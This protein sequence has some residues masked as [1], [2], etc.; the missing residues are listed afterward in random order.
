[1]CGKDEEGDG[2]EEG[3]IPQRRGR[4]DGAARVFDKAAS[5]IPTTRMLEEDM[6][7]S[8][9]RHVVY[10]HKLAFALQFVRYNETTKHFSWEYTFEEI[11]DVMRQLKCPLFPYKK[12]TTKRERDEEDKPFAILRDQFDVLQMS[13]WYLDLNQD[14]SY[15]SNSPNSRHVQE[16]G[17]T[18]FDTRDDPLMRGK[19]RST[20]KPAKERYLGYRA[21]NIEEFLLTK[22]KVNDA[23][24]LLSKA[25]K[26]GDLGIFVQTITECIT[27]EVTSSSANT[28]AERTANTY[29][30][31]SVH[32]QMMAVPVPSDDLLRDYTRAKSRTTPEHLVMYGKYL[33]GTYLFPFSGGAHVKVIPPGAAQRELGRAAIPMYDEIDYLL[34][35]AF[36]FPVSKTRESCEYLSKALA[37][38][39]KFVTVPSVKRTTD[40]PD[41]GS[42]LLQYFQN[43]QQ[44]AVGG[45]SRLLGPKTEGESGVT[46]APVRVQTFLV[47]MTEPNERRAVSPFP[48]DTY[49]KRLRTLIER[50]RT[51]SPLAYETGHPDSAFDRLQENNTT[52][53]HDHFSDFKRY[54]K[55]VAHITMASERAAE[56]GASKL[57]SGPSTLPTLSRLTVT[58]TLPSAETLL[59][60]A[61]VNDT[62]HTTGNDVITI[63]EGLYRKPKQAV[64]GE[65]DDLGSFTKHNPYIPEEKRVFMRLLQPDK[66]IG[67]V[68]YVQTFRQNLAD[69][70]SEYKREFMHYDTAIV[71][72]RAS[73]LAESIRTYTV[74]SLKQTV[75]SYPYHPVPAA[76]TIDISAR[77]RRG[78][79]P[80]FERSVRRNSSKHMSIR[81]P[82]DEEKEADDYDKENMGPN[83][84]E[85]PDGMY[86]SRAMN[87]EKMKEFSK[88]TTRR[89]DT[90][91][92]F[93]DSGPDTKKFNNNLGPSYLDEYTPQ[94]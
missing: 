28:L 10:A 16:T 68:G 77:E 31:D 64:L 42:A 37:L 18:R 50:D 80:D 58:R 2:R 12:H 11:R 1:M 8:G 90:A 40:R 34:L 62:Q 94:A 45:I 82:M 74:M 85:I 54:N 33:G 23:S 56:T 71:R 83:V 22:E 48:R 32:T 86:R 29:M 52:L 36:G 57:P 7:S 75:P 9:K 79:V 17:G 26:M 15:S 76:A 19:T 92:D 66:K 39:A 27:R 47:N 3:G 49:A 44:H 69:I 91:H 87:S 88:G 70:F 51:Q 81:I 61:I 73:L 84:S 55:L 38:H 21:R 14:S 65:E 13:R 67:P 59:R 20:S 46:V 72:A 78:S 25:D 93:H 63:T 60:Y 35:L 53:V 30:S 43:I 89:L 6:F 41:F 5:F 24:R 4:T